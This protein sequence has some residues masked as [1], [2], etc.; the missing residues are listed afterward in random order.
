VDDE[1][2]EAASRFSWFTQSTGHVR[3][4][5]GKQ[6]LLHRFVAGADGDLEIDHINGNPLDNRR[7]NLRF[8][9]H[10]QNMA[11]R[12]IRKDNRSGYKGVYWQ[13]PAN[14]WAACIKKNSKTT[15][16][17]LFRDA[18][19]AARAYDKAAIECY[20]EFARTNFKY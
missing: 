16:L 1:D 4:T 6:T 11:N 8:C 19:E 17:G 18:S 15:Y 3:M 14:K 7:E 20:G 13:K 12:K 9:S 2:F 5:G 10:A